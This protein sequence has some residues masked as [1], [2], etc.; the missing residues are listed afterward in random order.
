MQI[1][2]GELINP[3]RDVGHFQIDIHHPS[4]VCP[5]AAGRVAGRFGDA[6]HFIDVYVCE[7]IN[8]ALY[9]I[10]DWMD[11]MFLIRLKNIRLYAEPFGYVCHNLKI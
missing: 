3:L 11:D 7:R 9:E 8:A 1:F 4:I 5:H 6:G 2:V 10:E